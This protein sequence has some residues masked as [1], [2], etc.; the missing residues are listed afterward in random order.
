MSTAPAPTGALSRRGTHEPTG[1][2]TK[3]FDTMRR[4][5][6]R[7]PIGLVL[8]VP[9]VGAQL[10]FAFDALA[11]GQISDGGCLSSDGSGGLPTATGAPSLTGA[12]SVAVSPE[13]TTV[14]AAFNC[15]AVAVF[16][17]APADQLTYAGCVSD[18]G[19][20]G[21]CADLARALA[22]ANDLSLS[23]DG[24]TLVPN[25]TVTGTNANSRI[26][27]NA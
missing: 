24:T 7:L 27:R 18:D 5:A 22:A 11:L 13:G 26:T 14:C 23:A 10:V 17:R 21:L 25:T 4:L 16:N 6:G 8:G 15:R 19:S 9:A 3:P 2:Q 20:G 1:P 12:T